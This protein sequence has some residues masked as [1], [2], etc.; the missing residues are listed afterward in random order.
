MVTPQCSR[1]STE[2]WRH[3]NRRRLRRSDVRFHVTRLRA[4]RVGSAVCELRRFHDAAG[5]AVDISGMDQTL[6]RCHLVWPRHARTFL[7]TRPWAFGFGSDALGLAATFLCLSPA[8][9]ST[10]TEQIL[11]CRAVTN[12]HCRR[13]ARCQLR[14]STSDGTVATT[15][16]HQRN[17]QVPPEPAKGCKSIGSKSECDANRRCQW[18]SESERAKAYCRVIDCRG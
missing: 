1:C 8:T 13:Y 9:G 3:N 7:G 18:M 12:R 14:L 10:S 15:A 6:C 5:V 2:P 16:T 17:L 11:L 4:S